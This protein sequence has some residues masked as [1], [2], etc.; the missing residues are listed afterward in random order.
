MQMKIET[1][2]TILIY[3]NGAIVWKHEGEVEKSE[4]MKVIGQN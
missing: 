3:K 2:P 1:L 4:L